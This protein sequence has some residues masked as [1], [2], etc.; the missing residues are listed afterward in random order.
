MMQSLDGDDQ[1]VQV[2]SATKSDC[3]QPCAELGDAY[4][5]EDL[6]TDIKRAF[7]SRISYSHGKS[8]LLSVE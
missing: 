2:K 4:Q 5:K 8:A 1:V 7:E 6:K 3:K